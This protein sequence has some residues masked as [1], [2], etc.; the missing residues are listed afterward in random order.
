MPYSIS[1]FKKLPK[2]NVVW[3][4]S[5]RCNRS[6]INL[7]K[8]YMEANVLISKAKWVGEITLIFSLPKLKYP[9]K[10]YSDRTTVVYVVVIES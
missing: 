3:P 9:F 4:R 1:T 2:P 7:A 6:K 8:L 5:L 10:T